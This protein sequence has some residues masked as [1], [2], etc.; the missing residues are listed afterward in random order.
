MKSAVPHG[1]ADW[2]DMSK[3]RHEYILPRGKAVKKS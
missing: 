3:N 2:Y 1:K